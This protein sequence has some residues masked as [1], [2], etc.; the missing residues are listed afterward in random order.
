[1]KVG[2][3]TRLLEGIADGLADLS[4]T[5]A[6]GLTGFHKAMQPFA[7]Q[8][9][10]QFA[11]FLGQCEEYKR[12]GIIAGGKKAP[13]RVK[14]GTLSVADAAER[15]KGLLAEVSQGTVTNAR[16][17]SLLADIR[18]GFTKAKWLELL[19]ALSIAG[20]ANTIDQAVEKVRQVLNAQ[21]E[22]HVKAQAHGVPHG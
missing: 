18:K 15:V 11:A 8:T 22:M 13:A 20:K 7:E 9:V 21:L 1:V 5:T 12:T 6:S 10:D 2:E 16:I 19:A 3:V 4:K 14:A 17:D